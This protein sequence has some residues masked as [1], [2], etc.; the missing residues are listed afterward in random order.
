MNFDIENYAWKYA[1]PSVGSGNLTFG[2]ADRMSG[3]ECFH[4]YVNLLQNS[5][6]SGYPDGWI[7]TLSSLSDAAHKSSR[8]SDSRAE[9]P[10]FVKTPDDELLDIKDRFVINNNWLDEVFYGDL[11]A[12]LQTEK[13][14]NLLFSNYSESLNGLNRSIYKIYRLIRTDWK[15]P[16]DG[17]VLRYVLDKGQDVVSVYLDDVL[18][19]EISAAS[20]EI[21][22]NF[23]ATKGASWKTD[24]GTY[25][26]LPDGGSFEIPLSVTIKGL[27]KQKA[28][29]K[30][31]CN[32][33]FNETSKQSCRL[34][35]GLG[36]VGVSQGWYEYVEIPETTIGI[37]DPD[38]VLNA[39]G[40]NRIFDPIPGLGIFH[41]EASNNKEAKVSLYETD[42]IPYSY[43]DSAHLPVD[44]ATVRGAFNTLAS[45][46][47]DLRPGLSNCTFQEATLT[48]GNP[49]DAVRKFNFAS[50]SG[51]GEWPHDSLKCTPISSKHFAPFANMFTRQYVGYFSQDDKAVVLDVA[52][53]VK[54]GSGTEWIYTILEPEVE[55][56]VV[57]Y[58]LPASLSD[59]KEQSFSRFAPGRFLYLEPSGQNKGITSILATDQTPYTDGDLSISP[60]G[61]STRWFH[62]H[63]VFNNPLILAS[64]KLYSELTKDW[65]PS[66][67][68][69]FVGNANFTRLPHTRMAGKSVGIKNDTVCV[70]DS[71]YETF[72]LNEGSILFDFECVGIRDIVMPTFTESSQALHS[73]FNLDDT[74]LAMI[75]SD[76]YPC[77][78]RVGPVYWF[79]INEYNS[80][81]GI[82]RG[83]AHLGRNINS[84]S[85]LSNDM[86]HLE[87]AVSVESFD[88]T[89]AL[90]KSNTFLD[91]YK[92][93][94][95][96]VYDIAYHDNHLW[97]I[98]H[99]GMVKID[100]DNRG[101]VKYAW[102]Q[103]SVEALLESKST[104][105]EAVTIKLFV[106][107]GSLVAIF[108]YAGGIKY[109]EISIVTNDGISEAV[110]SEVPS[111]VSI[112]ANCNDVVQLPAFSGNLV[113]NSSSTNWTVTGEDFSTDI[114]DGVEVTSSTNLFFGH[115][116]VPISPVLRSPRWNRQSGSSW[117]ISK[118][119]QMSAAPE[120]VKRTIPVEIGHNVKFLTSISDYCNSNPMPFF[121]YVYS[122]ATDTHIKTRS[123]PDN[124]LI[125]IMSH[126]SGA[127]LAS[128]DMV[129]ATTLTI[130]TQKTATSGGSYLV[131]QY[132][133]DVN[134]SSS[135][136]E[137]KIGDKEPSC[138][139]PNLKV[140]GYFGSKYNYTLD[141][142]F[143]VVPYISGVTGSSF[144]TWLHDVSGL[145]I[146]T[147][148]ISSPATSATESTNNQHF[149]AGPLITTS[150]ANDFN[151]LVDQW[152]KY[153]STTSLTPE[154]S[155]ISSHKV[156]VYQSPF[157]R[158]SVSVSVPWYKIVHERGPN[159][160]VG[161]RDNLDIDFADDICLYAGSP[162][163]PYD[164]NNS[165]LG[166]LIHYV[167]KHGDKIYINGR[168]IVNAI[169]MPNFIGF[170]RHYLYQKSGSSIVAYDPWTG[171]AV[172]D[173]SYDTTETDPII[174]M[175]AKAG[176]YASPMYALGSVFD[177][178]VVNNV[179]PGAT[180]ASY[181]DRTFTKTSPSG[182]FWSLDIVTV[183]GKFYKSLKYSR[184]LWNSSGVY[185]VLEGLR[186]GFTIGTLAGG[187]AGNH[188]IMHVLT[189]ISGQVEHFYA[190]KQD[191]RTDD[192]SYEY[193]G[194]YSANV[195][196]PSE[197]GR[198]D[199]SGKD[200]STTVYKDGVMV[201][202]WANPTGTLRESG[203]NNFDYSYGLF[204]WDSND[205]S[206][207]TYPFLQD[208]SSWYQNEASD[209]H[210]NFPYVVSAPE[211]PNVSSNKASIT[212][213]F[214][215]VQEIDYA[216]SG[217]RENTKYINGSGSVVFNDVYREWYNEIS[218]NTEYPEPA[219]LLVYDTGFQNYSGYH[220]GHGSGSAF[221][222]SFVAEKDGEP[223]YT[224]GAAPWQLNKNIYINARA[225]HP[226]IWHG[227]VAMP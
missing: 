49:Y 116:S 80:N 119:I 55:R 7:D 140:N 33:G 38:K 81:Y 57:G 203:I 122:Y 26:N 93:D 72:R 32:L 159:G 78:I 103:E 41:I 163:W 141:G 158:P 87:E 137:M 60:S 94:F 145:I 197:S 64:G 84:Q 209:P 40:V 9:Y 65:E 13:D 3:L 126:R 112:L 71:S 102:E 223:W 178:G 45:G 28:I 184:F 157:D 89:Y 181:R 186:P 189:A 143:G 5:V 220:G 127:N 199:W 73:K 115:L 69:S 211:I 108:N 144:N 2:P 91:A 86:F 74:W 1:K 43:L 85:S 177:Y 194:Q 207:A 120:V 17:D 70:F 179:L 44:L 88:K 82:S 61:S 15:T 37:E 30:C 155:G 118:L 12:Y 36:Y 191:K 148:G 187:D 200:F 58:P 130:G 99:A 123:I 185:S 11:G 109:Y 35:F 225:T 160:A 195:A 176:M 138:R 204:V 166:D 62:N 29:E 50:P 51:T 20:G 107:S 22:V 170:D 34:C 92:N 198:T 25:A 97:A 219:T 222:Y 121:G 68:L 156:V 171:E 172:T 83:Y 27:K 202:S 188:N 212:A 63:P 136:V 125:G 147:H 210:A 213:K 201:T 14:N 224:T 46:W 174:W 192:I 208:N 113:K 75:D 150:G 31:T 132:V 164:Q 161:L 206:K 95:R 106:N 104:D 151:L 167:Q 135:F 56:E 114:S 101:I 139:G 190:F 153:S 111:P 42:S 18:I 131:P 98:T 105:A 128:F 218:G 193:L 169:E 142:N 23:K 152:Q 221:S 53:S 154:A 59:W 133:Y 180:N 149:V 110:V 4:S 226:S 47:N 54:S 146:H 134:G 96:T 196:H 24:L 16:G 79:G 76:M 10:R 100:F 162:S 19:E 90:T 183:K 227:Y 214:V 165:S 168:H 52:A 173:R 182:D 8:N 6:S 48:S 67:E 124:N 217:T 117:S 129:K 215:L 205:D 21:Y 39:S 77:H 216:T 175:S 66:G